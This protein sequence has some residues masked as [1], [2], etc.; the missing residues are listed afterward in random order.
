M[1][2]IGRSIGAEVDGAWTVKI[3]LLVATLMMTTSALA[4]DVPKVG[5]KPLL[6]V[7]PKGPAGC[8]LVG[9]VK[10]T[11]LWA[12]DCIATESGGVSS[13][14]GSQTSLPVETTAAILP[15]QKQ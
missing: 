3:V 1:R 11:K 15:G 14:T 13:V 4:Q 6:Q 9:T 12:G 5:G 10:G 2:V 8:K 7:K